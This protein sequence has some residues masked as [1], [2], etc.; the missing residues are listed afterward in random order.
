MIAIHTSFGAE[1]LYKRLVGSLGLAQ[2]DV[3]VLDDETTEAPEASV[4]VISVLDRDRLATVLTPQIRW[5]HV[6]GTGVDGFPFELMGDRIL[7][8]SRGANAAPIAEYVLAAMLS[9]EKRMPDIW[10]SGREEFQ[11]FALGQLSGRTLGLVGLG[12]IGS[13]TARRALSFDMNVIAVRRSPAKSSVPGVTVVAALSDALPLCDHLVVAAPATTETKHLID[14]SA[15]SLMKKGTHFVNISR[16]SLV[17]QDA[18]L[19]AL[20]DGTV[21]MATL[22]VTDP[23]PLPDGHPLYSHPRVRVSPHVSWSAPDTLRMTVAM[24]EENFRRHVAGQPLDGV[25]DMT[26]GY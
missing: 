26:A 15:F 5:V 1:A 7:T 8:C 16:G 14:K 12:S 20:E 10:I 2:E 23:E 19:A 24:F 11:E 4:L 17:D 21:E 25:V 18:L 22:D 3:V 13:A 9:F 6:L